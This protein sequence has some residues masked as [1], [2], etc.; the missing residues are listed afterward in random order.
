MAPSPSSRLRPPSRTPSLSASEAYSAS[1]SRNSAL[2]WSAP[3]LGPA[4]SPSAPVATLPRSTMSP[5]AA[6]PSLYADE[7]RN[8]LVTV[9]VSQM[10]LGERETELMRVSCCYRDA[11]GEETEKRT[12]VEV[13]RV[14]RPDSVAE[15]EA[16]VVVDRQRNRQRAAEAMAEARAAAERGELLEAAAERGELM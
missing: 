2:T 4:S 3:A 8:F 6:A 10:R 11:V 16:A 5:A 15:Q 14:R 12:E 9:A 13:V 7:E 1:S